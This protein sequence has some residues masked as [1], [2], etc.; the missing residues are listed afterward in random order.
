MPEKEVI[1]NPLLRYT[2]KFYKRDI[3]QGLKLI[4]ERKEAIIRRELLTFELQRQAERRRIAQV[5]EDAEND[6]TV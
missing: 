5:K 3:K 6:D 2:D 1:T 4:A